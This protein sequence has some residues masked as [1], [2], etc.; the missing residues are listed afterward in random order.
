MNKADKGY[1][2]A[3]VTPPERHPSTYKK[4]GEKSRTRSPSADGKGKDSKGK[5]KDDPKGKGGKKGKGK[6]GKKG[7]KNQPYHQRKGA[8]QTWGDDQWGA[9]PW[10]D[11]TVWDGGQAWDNGVALQQQQ[12]QQ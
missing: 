8:V 9:E 2:A 10:T 1:L 7:D 12:Q 5:G 4:D 3:G 11:D 6:G